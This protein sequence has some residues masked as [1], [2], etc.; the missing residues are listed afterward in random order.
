MDRLLAFRVVTD[1]VH[2]GLKYA[3]VGF[4]PLTFARSV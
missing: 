1:D 4:L 2:S 3:H